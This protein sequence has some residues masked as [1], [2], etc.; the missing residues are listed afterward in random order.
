VH[1]LQV[2]IARYV[3]DHQPGVVACEFTDADGRLHTIIDKASLFTRDRLGTASHYP[4]P[5]IVHC[6][7]LGSFLDDDGRALVRIKLER[8]DHIQST[9]GLT[10]FVVL[11]S[12]VV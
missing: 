4:H 1:N 12:Q 2:Q 9:K 7:V 5:G 11:E 6:E 8:S 3:D 10:Q